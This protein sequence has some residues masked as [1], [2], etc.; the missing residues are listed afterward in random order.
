M[1]RPPIPLLERWNR[2]LVKALNAPDVKAELFRHGLTPQPGSRDELA[3]LIASESATWG[4][5]IRERKI[6]AD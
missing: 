6:T 1:S 4:Q 2:E 3:R 5:L